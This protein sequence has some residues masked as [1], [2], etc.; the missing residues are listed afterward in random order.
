MPNRDE[1]GGAA[2]KGAYI[3]VD[4]PTEAGYDAF[5]AD[6]NEFLSN[7]PF[8]EPYV[9][10]Y[11][12]CPSM[13]VDSGLYL[14]TSLAIDQFQVAQ[15]YETASKDFPW[16]MGGSTT[17]EI[18]GETKYAF[19]ECFYADQNTGGIY[20]YNG[21]YPPVENPSEPVYKGI[22]RKIK[23]IYVGV[24]GIARKVKKAYIGVGGVARLIFEDALQPPTGEYLTFSSPKAFTIA[25]NNNTKNWDGT[26]E[27]YDG[28]WVTWDGTTAIPSINSTVGN[29]VFLRG[30]SNT[31][32]TGGTSGRN[33]LLDGTDIK[34]NGNI[35]TLLDHATVEQGGHPTMASYCYSS[36]FYN[37]TSLTKAPALP[38]TTLVTSCY[39]YM[40][41][42]CTS[43]TQA[44][45]LPATTLATSCYSAM[46]KCCTSLTQAPELPATTFKT[47]CYSSMFYN[48][49]SLTKAPAL[50]AT[51]LVT[52]CY[53]YMFY[54]CTSLTQVPAL[55]AT[56][57]AIGCYSNMFY[58]CSKIKISKTLTEEYTKAYRIPKSGTGTT[59][60]GS[61]TNMFTRTGGTFKETPT[62]NTT[63][64][65]SSTNTIV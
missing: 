1:T 48:C 61:L 54:G 64:Y 34:C 62:I 13:D 26:L 59:T 63:Y 4:T 42:G 50:P 55:P 17:I 23:K 56:T 60:T 46:F 31:V 3:G 16:A 25:T 30:N 53:S 40:F 5:Y 14:P 57:L 15:W 33:W 38:A 21:N 47:G 52:N 29:S 9:L 20:V 49:T 10:A 27:Y 18:D 7:Y 35:E 19:I 2:N 6:P 44:P 28:N 65:L 32:I 43:L 41:Y 22:A 37:C 8:A 11:E 24:N 12:T 45:E 51:T 39:S 36:M 58:G